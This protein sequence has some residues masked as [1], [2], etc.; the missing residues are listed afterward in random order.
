MSPSEAPKTKAPK[1]G[2]SKNGRALQK[3]AGHV[4]HKHKHR[5]DSKEPWSC[6]FLV[7]NRLVDEDDSFLKSK[8]VRGGQVADA[9]GR[10]LFLPKDMKVWQEKRS[11]HMLEN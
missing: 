3:A 8:D 2:K 1:K 7:D 9:V 10:A 4:S 5:N 6:A 11:E